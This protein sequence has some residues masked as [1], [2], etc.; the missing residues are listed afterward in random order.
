MPV[1]P[2]F[3][4]IFAKIADLDMMQVL[5]DPEAMARFFAAT[6]PSPDYSAPAAATEDRVVA[7]PH[8]DVPIRI[9][10]PVNDEPSGVGVVWAHDGGWAYGSINDP[11]SDGFARE[12]VART[13]AVVVTID[14]RLVN[15][16]TKY[17]V[18]LDDYEAAFSWVQ[19]HAEELE[20][21]PARL[22]LGGG[23]VAA[24]MSVATAL[25]LRDSGSALPAGLLVTFSLTHRVVP[26]ASAEQE[27]KFAV[28]APLLRFGAPMVEMMYGNYLGEQAVDA[29]AAPAIA[30]LTG[31]PRTL[32]ITSEYDDLAPDG[33]HFAELLATAGVPVRFVE[34]A[35][36]AHAHLN[37]PWTDGAQRSLDL[38]AEWLTTAPASDTEGALSLAI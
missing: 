33:E 31:L 25:R 6:G 23:G 32:V 3:A 12:I 24:N 28:V 29:Y 9:Y 15:E 27:E 5:S 34:E 7:G 37:Y 36:V 14:Y 16:T 1:D 2:Q 11:G 4:E 10:R 19:A 18:P 13:R 38:I 8:G 17:P 21:D 26:P 20:I 22:V 35:G 30:D